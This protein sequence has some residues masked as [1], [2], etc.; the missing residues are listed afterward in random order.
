MSDLNKALVQKFF[1]I[2]NQGAWGQL[3]SL[4]SLD[5]IHHS[6]DSQLTLAQFKRGAAWLRAGMPDFQIVSEDLISETDKVAARCIGRGTHLASFFGESPTSKTVTIYFT[7]IYRI[8][9]SLIV[10]DWEAADDAYFMKQI[11]ASA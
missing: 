9:N 6:N 10:E 4:V 3:D 2:Y 5:Y 8:Q 7:M 11:G 1:D